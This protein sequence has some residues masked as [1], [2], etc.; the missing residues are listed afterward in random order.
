MVARCKLRAIFYIELHK[1]T[2]SRRW[3]NFL[4]NYDLI[5]FLWMNYASFEYF[6]RLITLAGVPIRK[7]PTATR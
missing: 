1:P 7:Y 5:S 3:A 6:R 2:S 4:E